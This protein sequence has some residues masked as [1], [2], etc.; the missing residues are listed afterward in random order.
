M[1]ATKYLSKSKA[2]EN[3]WGKK[4]TQKK[5]TNNK[6]GNKNVNY[7]HVWPIIS[8]ISINYAGAVCGWHYATEDTPNNHCVKPKDAF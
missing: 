3:W 1:V 2:L 6:T 7:S 4:T 5:T 8:K